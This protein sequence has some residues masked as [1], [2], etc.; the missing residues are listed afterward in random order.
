M[1]IKCTNREVSTHSDLSFWITKNIL[2]RTELQICNE[3]NIL[4]IWIWNAQPPA[5]MILL[6]SAQQL[7]QLLQLEDQSIIIML[8][9]HQPPLHPLLFCARLCQ[10]LFALCGCHCCCD[11]NSCACHFLCHHYPFIQKN[12]NCKNSHSEAVLGLFD[13]AVWNPS[14][15]LSNNTHFGNWKN[16]KINLI[17]WKK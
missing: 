17:K 13:D 15:I 9:L 1:K 7:L 8:Q 10:R 4:L 12:I 14:L 16:K 5:V 6:S 3:L 11:Y 2:K